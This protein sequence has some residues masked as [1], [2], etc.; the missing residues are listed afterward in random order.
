MKR[1]YYATVLV[2]AFASITL[3]LLDIAGR[4]NL[5]KPPLMYLD[6]GILVFFWVDYIVRFIRAENKGQ[7]F[8]SNF[9]D[10][11]AI[12]PF[13]SFL[14]FFRAFRIFRLLK[15]LQL[16]RII[17]FTG[18]IHIQVK[19]FFNTNGFIYL[20]ITAVLIILMGAEAYSFAEHVNYENSLWWAIATT[21]TVGYGDISPHTASG[22]AIAVVLMVV[23]IGLI[24][25]ITST[26]TAFFL[27]ER[28]DKENDELR[29]ELKQIK[30]TL[31]EL[32]D[33]LD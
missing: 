11:L 25:S 29:D 18:K 30:K 2:L 27:T 32:K 4:I 23:G 15:L 28:S 20:V 10:L 12:I 31:N 3:A 33:K 7:F 21:T 19:R 8:K 5:S 16:L 14:Y 26:V 6:I 17:G 9:F 1:A 22:R 24:G 13:S